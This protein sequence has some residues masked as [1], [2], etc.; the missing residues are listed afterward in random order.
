[1]T[2]SSMNP[3]S[4]CGW[5]GVTSWPS[6]LTSS[7]STTTTSS[8]QMETWP[9]DV[10]RDTV[11]RELQVASAADVV[12]VLQRLLCRSRA[13]LHH[14]RLLLAALEELL[15]WLTA[16]PGAEILNGPTMDTQIWRSITREASFG[17]NPSTTSTGTVNTA[18]MVLVQP[19]LPASHQT[20]RDELPGMS[21]AVIAHLRRRAWRRHVENLGP[22]GGN[23][24]SS[25]GQGGTDA[26]LY[27]VQIDA[28]RRVP[29][30]PGAE[31]FRCMPLRLHGGRRRA[32]AER[33]RAGLEN[34][35]G[36]T[37]LLMRSTASIP[38]ERP[39]SSNADGT[40]AGAGGGRSS[41]SSEQ[42][43]RGPVSLPAQRDRSRSRDDLTA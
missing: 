26:D 43:R 38:S 20:I 21:S 40:T 37:P 28:S 32:R 16:T 25:G 4:G 41:R 15:P 8:E 7:T 34:R 42:R 12:D 33:L 24:S 5:C 11:T 2:T 3:A 22:A 19:G 30:P 13:R 9:D 29:V 31:E 35:G 39:S 1:M 14:Q 27:L 23:V 10:V 17:S 6:L 36:A 18:P